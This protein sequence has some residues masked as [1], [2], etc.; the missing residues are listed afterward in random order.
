MLLLLSADFFQFNC[1]KKIFQEHIDHG[2]D[3][4]QDRCQWF[5]LAIF[6]AL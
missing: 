1:F 3:P 5:Y 4:D 2:L 6:T